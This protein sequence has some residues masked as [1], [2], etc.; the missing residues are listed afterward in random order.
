MI[1]LSYEYKLEPT[2][3]QVEVFD[4]WLE[5]CRKVYNFALAERK[6]YVNSRS[7]TIDACS[8]RCEYIIPADAPRPTYHS[9]ARALTIAKKL[10]SE[11]K[12]PP[13][14]VLQKTL[15][16]VENAF[17]NMYERGFGFPRFKKK[18]QLRSFVFP[19][20]KGDIIQN[21]KV[22]LPKIGQIKIRY[23]RPIPEG[24]VVKQAR[25]VKKASGFYVILVCQLDVDVPS[26]L[27]PPLEGQGCFIFP[28]DSEGEREKG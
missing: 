23:S 28:K 21:G 11:L 12:I 3:E 4:Q 17:V 2:V 6:D 16:R 22:K 18:G 5:I 20:L 13:A 24:F 10:I 7:S 25:V 14:Q 1:N 26:P 19:Q 8:L 9:Q 27:R 15:E